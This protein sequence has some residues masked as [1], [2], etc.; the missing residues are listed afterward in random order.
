M[1]DDMN[2]WQPIETAPKDGTIVIVWPPTFTGAMS[3]ARYDAQKHH[4]R[5]RPFWYR[6]DS[7]GGTFLCRERAPTHWRPVLTGPNGEK[8]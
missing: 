2:G 6:L 8:P 7:Y 5:P 1:S 4:L 3:C